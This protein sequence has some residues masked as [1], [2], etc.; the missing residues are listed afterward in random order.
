MRGAGFCHYN[1]PS[2]GSRGDA[3]GFA[4]TLPHQ[5]CRQWT[6]KDAEPFLGRI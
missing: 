3:L 6:H 1:A 4:L 5:F 2:C